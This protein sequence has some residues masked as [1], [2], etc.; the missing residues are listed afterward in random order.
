MTLPGPIGLVRVVILPT[1]VAARRRAGLAGRPCGPPAAIP[2]ARQGRHPALSLEVRRDAVA[3]VLLDGLSYRRAGRMWASPRPRSAT[4]WTCCLVC[5][6]RWGA[7]NPTAPSSPLS[8]ILAGGLGRWPCPA[9]RC[10]STDSPPGCNDPARGPTRRS[11]TTPSATSTPPRGWRWPPSGRPVV[12]RRRLAGQLP[13]ARV[14]C[15]GG[16]GGRAG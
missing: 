3:A 15:A 16:A 6:P 4:A 1:F 7:A 12:V 9:R 11:C 10:A 14:A 8:P 13:R 2:P 5:W